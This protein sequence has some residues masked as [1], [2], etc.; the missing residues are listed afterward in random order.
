MMEAGHILVVMHLLVPAAQP[1]ASPCGATQVTSTSTLTLLPFGDHFLPSLSQWDVCTTLR[2]LLH[3]SVLG[4]L[5]II[6][7]RL[8]KSNARMALTPRAAPSR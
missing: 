6:C 1:P 3:K 5:K 7:I 4:L 2:L 8:E